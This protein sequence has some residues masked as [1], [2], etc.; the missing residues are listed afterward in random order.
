MNCDT[1]IKFFGRQ[2]P[3]EFCLLALIFDG[4]SPVK[5]LNKYLDQVAPEMGEP[6]EEEYEDMVSQVSVPETFR[7]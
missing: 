4:D 5:A 2:T 1:W 3:Q 6:T 7:R